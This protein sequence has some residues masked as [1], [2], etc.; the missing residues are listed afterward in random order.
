M[1]IYQKSE[2]ILSNHNSWGSVFHEG[3]DILLDGL[4]DFLCGGK[5]CLG[6]DLQK[7]ILSEE[8]TVYVPSL[9]D[10]VGIKD[11]VLARV[12]EDLLILKE[13]LLQTA[14]DETG[15]AFEVAE[16]VLTP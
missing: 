4:V 9:G 16:V 10:A 2:M 12:E 5:L 7:P 14:Q 15:F 8:V 3:G 13:R 1:G 11:H 6:E